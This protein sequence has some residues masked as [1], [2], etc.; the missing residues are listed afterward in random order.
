MTDSAKKSTVPGALTI[1]LFAIYAILLVAIILF[2]FPFQYQLTSNGRELNL[3]PFGGS[4]TDFR[5]LGLGEVIENVLIFVPL[6]IYV[7]MLKNQ[8]SFARRALVIVATSVAFESIQ[9]AFA[10]GRADITD[11]ICNAFGGV[12]GIGLY[13]ISANIMRT[14]T[15]R[16]LNTVALVVTVIALAFFTFL[17]MHS[18]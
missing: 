6:G 9:F 13:A 11:V 8:W 14:R 1:V 5:R 17:R 18:K 12:V 15:N 4:Y 16:V 7:S 3:I 2:K 10:I